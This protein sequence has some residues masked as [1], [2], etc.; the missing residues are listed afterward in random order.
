[1]SFFLRARVPDIRFNYVSYRLA[2]PKMEPGEE[3]CEHCCE[4][5]YL[6]EGSDDPEEADG[7]CMCLIKAWDTSGSL[8]KKK[9]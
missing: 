1:M 3:V 2:D 8:K 7:Y 5:M 6:E 9:G 4:A